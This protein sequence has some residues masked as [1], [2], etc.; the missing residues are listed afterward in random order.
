MHIM[1]YMNLLNYIYLYINMYT[2]YSKSTFYSFEYI[3]VH[4]LDA[5]NAKGEV[6][7]KVAL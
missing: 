1:S 2:V 6:K 5:P 3:A 7:S 4:D